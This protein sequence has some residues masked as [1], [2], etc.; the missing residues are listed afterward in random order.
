MIFDKFSLIVALFLAIFDMAD[1]AQAAPQPAG[2]VGDI[3]AGSFNDGITV[4]ANGVVQ[5]GY[6]NIS[7]TGA[8]L[9][10]TVEI[11]QG[12]YY[13]GTTPIANIT[14]EGDNH[15]E[16]MVTQQEGVDLIFQVVDASGK[17]GTLPLI[18][19]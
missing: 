7:W 13:I 17:T 15:T 14:V 1:R 8:S 5:C 2:L 18:Q 16:W 19:A 3:L 4:T 6:A 11:G 12:G 10:V 9:P